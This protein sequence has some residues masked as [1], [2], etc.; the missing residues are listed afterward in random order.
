MMRSKLNFSE[1]KTE[2]NPQIFQE[3]S[4]FDQT[5]QFQN[6][7]QFDLKKNGKLEVGDWLDVKDTVGQWLEA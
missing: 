6:L 2:P 4:S 3:E 1:S 5:S 7:S